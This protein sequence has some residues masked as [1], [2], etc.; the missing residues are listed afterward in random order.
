MSDVDVQVEEEG[1]V[2][3]EV[4]GATPPADQ[5]ATANPDDQASGGVAEQQTA[6]DDAAALLLKAQKDL[7]EER[8]RREASDATANAERL[9]ADEADRVARQTSED[10]KTAREAAQSSQIAQVATSIE[11]AAARVNTAKADLQRA[12]EAGD[13]PKVAEAQDALADAKA[14]LKIG[15]QRKADLE[16]AAQRAPSHEGRVE[17]TT[18]ASPVE[19]YIA[20][21]RFTPLAAAWLR[22]HP[23]CIPSEYGGNAAKN[24][25]MMSGHWAALSKGLQVNS[26][27]YFALI[28]SSINPVSAAAVT[29]PPEEAP[30][31]QV[32]QRRA[33]PSAP[34]SRDQ[35]DGGGAQDNPRTVR[36]NALQ[37]EAALFSYPQ[38]PGEADDAWKKRA[39]GT[40]AR[41]F[42]KARNE[43]KIGRLTH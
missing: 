31:P 22:G 2:N 29:K 30:K 23:D 37:Q 38:N 39:F 20:A 28:E 40:Y 42:I 7:D 21:G 1:V 11:T 41:E 18:F 25:Q 15:Q 35:T 26:P 43:G 12:L 36:L 4:E 8:R 3:V 16:T 24:A 34:P 10:A 9:R 33:A 13:F 14:D 32:Q 27:E 6:V 17:R 19:Q 5:T